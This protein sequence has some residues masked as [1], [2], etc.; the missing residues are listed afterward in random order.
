MCGVVLV[1]QLR[2]P[3]GAGHAGGAS[4][5]DDHVGFHNGTFDIGERLTKNYHQTYPED[6]QYKC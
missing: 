3:Q 4:A 5:D 2:E 6:L 1:D